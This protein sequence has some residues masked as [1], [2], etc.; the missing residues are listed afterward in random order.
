VK[1]EKLDLLLHL[2]LEDTFAWGSLRTEWR[3]RPRFLRC[4]GKNAV[5]L[6]RLGVVG[7]RYVSRSALDYCC[8]GRLGGFSYEC[9]FNL[10]LAKA[11][12]IKSVS[13]SFSF[14]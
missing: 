5:S 6:G 7:V 2:Q 1:E 8:A 3:C 11:E 13:D 4:L 10:R 9:R 14:S 12:M